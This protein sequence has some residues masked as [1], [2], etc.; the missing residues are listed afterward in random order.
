MHRYIGNKFMAD[1]RTSLEN[2]FHKLLTRLFGKALTKSMLGNEDFTRITSI[3][4]TDR[5]EELW[6]SQIAQ[7]PYDAACVAEVD[8][9]DRLSEEVLSDLHDT[10]KIQ[11]SHRTNFLGVVTG[12]L[13]NVLLY[14]QEVYGA[15]DDAPLY[16]TEVFV[17][18]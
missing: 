4:M 16:I 8:L 17:N 11:V 12:Q 14:L 2:D 9:A 10:Y 7:L 3:I 1:K 6:R 5:V 15:G 18:D 13:G